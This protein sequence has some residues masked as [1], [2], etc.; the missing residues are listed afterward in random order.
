MCPRCHTQ[1]AYLSPRQ[2]PIPVCWFLARIECNDCNLI[3]YRWPYSRWTP[4]FSADCRDRGEHEE[5]Q[6][7]AFACVVA[8]SIIFVAVLTSRLSPRV[9]KPQARR[10]PPVVEVKESGESL[11]HL[12]SAVRQMSESIQSTKI[13]VSIIDGADLLDENSDTN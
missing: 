5:K 10:R 7:Y 4:G 6:R 1:R 13:D 11:R 8:L 2:P 9:K 3:Y 12:T